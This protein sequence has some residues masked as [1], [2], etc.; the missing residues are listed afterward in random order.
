[1]GLEALLGGD[2]DQ[3]AVE[4]AIAEF[5]AGRPVLV[6]SAQGCVLAAPA[7]GLDSAALAALEGLAGGAARLVLSA[8]RL[9][10][11]GVRERGP[12]AVALPDVDI[13][14][15]ARLA[16]A[17]IAAI[18][19]AVLPLLRA[20]DMALRLAHL[21]AL[22]PALVTVPVADDALAGVAIA[23]VEADAVGAYRARRAAA[24]H[25]VARAKVPLDGAPESEFVIFRGGEGLRDQAAVIVGDPDRAEPVAVRLHSAC[26]TGDLFGSLKCD[27]GD[28]LRMTA[29]YLAENG[30]GII[31]Y[32]DQEGRGNGLAS[33]IKAYRLQAD[34]FDT[35]DADEVLGFDEDQRAFDFAAEMLKQLGVSRVRILTNNPVKSD[36]LQAAGLEVV[37]EQRV[38]G[39]QTPQNAGYLA[40]KRLKA[41]H[42]IDDETAAARAAEKG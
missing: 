42:S 9:R 7:E 25:I 41:G 27:C 12:G 3:L 29:R 39:R 20:E 2:R 34:G 37:A 10:R 36:A 22:L 15:L 1:M 30:G 19:A 33:K 23:R 14:R 5:R 16:L 13:A 21:A 24:L 38:I 28:Q 40:A 18:D 32:L 11:L 35:F 31:L 26:L 4:R 17:E 6:E 8:A